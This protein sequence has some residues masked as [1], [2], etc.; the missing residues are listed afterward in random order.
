MEDIKRILVVSRDTK[1]CRK[2]VHYGVSLTR[3]FGAELYVIHVAD[4][5]TCLEG[6]L[7]DEEHQASIRKIREELAATIADENRNGLNVKELI[8][9]GY[10]ATEIF[11][12]VEDEHI[13]LI[14]LL[15]HEENHIE[16]FLF[17][18][19]NSEIIRQMPCSIFLVKKEP[20]PTKD[21]DL[22]R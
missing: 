1:H 5:P 8:K 11:R 14:I 21:A 6:Y 22:K 19:S 13:D 10:P 12:V 17:G 4:D 7:E 16:H 2:A 20:A 3:K 15:A 18:R 9:T